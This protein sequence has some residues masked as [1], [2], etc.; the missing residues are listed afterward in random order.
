MDADLVRYAEQELKALKRVKQV[1]HPY[2]LA[3]DRY[4]II[5]GRLMIVMELAD[6]NLWDRFR[7]C[8]DQR[9]PG[10]P[11]D[12]LLRYM[13][14]AAEVL[15]LM[16]D[17]YQLQHL[18]IKPQNLFLLYNHVKVADFGLVKD[19]E[20]LRGAGHRRHHA[21]VR[22]PGDVRRHRHPVLRPVQPRDACTRNCSPA[23]GRSTGPACSQLLM[24][25]LHVPPNLGPLP[26]ARPAGRRPGAGEEAGGPIAE[27]ASQFVRALSAAGT[28]TPA[29]PAAVPSRPRQETP[30]GTARVVPPLPPLA[31]AAGRRAAAAGRDAQDAAPPAPRRVAGRTPTRTPAPR[32]PCRTRRPAGGDRRRRAAPGASSS[33]SGR[34]GCDVL[35][36]FRRMTQERFGTADRVAAPRR[37]CSSTPTRKRCT[38]PRPSG[39]PRPRRKCSRPGSTARPTT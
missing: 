13:E 19:L 12:E 8:R 16:N 39:R 28:E 10:I 27:R 21:G 38:R 7:E 24:Q 15:D 6:C 35:R 36:E 22:R 17:Q 26:P 29:P 25:H 14:E 37:C 23:C 2:L 1:R 9:L 5:D 33:G 30:V 31:A 3:L 34:A 32:W 11:R 18:D 20:G 4:D